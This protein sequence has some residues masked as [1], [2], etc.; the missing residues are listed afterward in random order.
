MKWWAKATS[1]WKQQPMVSIGASFTSS[2]H[3]KQLNPWPNWPANHVV[4]Y[5]QLSACQREMEPSEDHLSTRGHLTNLSKSSLGNFQQE[6]LTELLMCTTI[7]WWWIVCVLLLC[8][9]KP[10]FLKSGHIWQI[11]KNKHV[12]KMFI[13]IQMA[14]TIALSLYHHVITLGD[15]VILLQLHN[16]WHDIILLHWL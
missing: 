11:T 15:T 6:Y 4:N 7:M 9:W 12:I 13:C 8:V 1:T 5:S 14:S 2:Y 16:V 10:T 3:T